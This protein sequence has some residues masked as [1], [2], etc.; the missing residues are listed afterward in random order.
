MGI[1]Y[2]TDRVHAI[3]LATGRDAKPFQP[4]VEAGYRGEYPLAR[5]QYLALNYKPGTDLD[6]LRKEFIRCVF[7]R[8]GQEAVVKAGYV[9]LSA[10]I[11][12]EQLEKV[13]LQDWVK[14]KN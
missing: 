8:Q 1:G 13:G 12:R 10:K 2:R 3:A 5:F 6:S 7:S 11:A 4:T 9:P 14:Q